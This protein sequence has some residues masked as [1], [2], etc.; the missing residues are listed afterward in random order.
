MS[1][2]PQPRINT[3]SSNGILNAVYQAW[4][5]SIQQWLGPV[6]MFGAT[7]ARPTTGLYIGLSYFGSTLGYPVF[8]KEV[9]PSIVWV[10]GS[11]GVV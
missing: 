7:A 1:L 5:N 4:F 11:G 9:S 6:G 2:S 3:I 8:V 10:N